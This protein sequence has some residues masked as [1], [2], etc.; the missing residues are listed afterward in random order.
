VKVVN[1][2]DARLETSTP[3]T[4]KSLVDE[5]VIGGSDPLNLL[6]YV[7][8]RLGC[9]PILWLVSQFG[10]FTVLIPELV[11]RTLDFRDSTPDVTSPCE[12]TP[13]HPEKKNS[14]RIRG[15]NPSA[16][17]PA[18]SRGKKRTSP[19]KK[20]SLRTAQSPKKKKRKKEEELV[21]DGSDEDPSEP[22]PTSEDD[23]ESESGTKDSPPPKT[24]P[25]RKQLPLPT[26]VAP[27]HN[28]RNSDLRE[29]GH[30]APEGK[31]NEEGYGGDGGKSLTQETTEKVASD[32][33]DLR[34]ISAERAA[35]KRVWVPSSQSEATEFQFS[36]TDPLDFK[37]DF[38]TEVNEHLKTMCL[39][40]CEVTL[41]DVIRKGDCGY[42]CLLLGLRELE[43]DNRLLAACQDSA[44]PLRKELAYH[45]FGDANGFKG[46]FDEGK[47]AV[48]LKN[49]TIRKFLCPCLTGDAVEIMKEYQSYRHRLETRSAGLKA[50]LELSH[51]ISSLEK[52]EMKEKPSQEQTFLKQVQSTKNLSDK[53]FGE[54]AL[55]QM[56]KEAR[57]Q[58]N[59]AEKKSPITTDT[60]VAFCHLH[61]P[62]WT[63]ESE[64][65]QEYSE[66]SMSLQLGPIL[67]ASRYKCQVVVYHLRNKALKNVYTADGRGSEFIYKGEDADSL[68]R[69]LN[70]FPVKDPHNRTVYLC[71]ADVNEEGAG[72][73][74]GH[75]TFIQRQYHEEHAH[76]YPITES[77]PPP[78][79]LVPEISEKWDESSRVL[80]YNT[81]KP[82][83]QRLSHLYARN[84]LTVI[85]TNVFDVKEREEESWHQSSILLRHES[86]Y[87]CEFSVQDYKDGLHREVEKDPSFT[88]NLFWEHLEAYKA[89]VPAKSI[90]YMKDVPLQQMAP[91]MYDDFLK[92]LT[93]KDSLPG[94]SF[95]MLKGVS[96]FLSRVCLYPWF[97][98]YR[99]VACSPPSKVPFTTRPFMGPSLYTG[100]PG[101]HT[102]LHQDGLGSVDSAHLCISGYNE[103]VI[104]RRLPEQHK[105]NAISLLFDLKEEDDTF[106]I[107]L[108][109]GEPHDN[110]VRTSPFFSFLFQLLTPDNSLL[111]KMKK[112]NRER[113]G[114]PTN[115]G[116]ERCRKKG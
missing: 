115:E 85:L 14:S 33:L 35:E 77:V 107:G 7:E 51:E 70:G 30:L 16:P 62:G 47:I 56:E 45:A 67:F 94:G 42:Y 40:Y 101:P 31:T 54:K 50:R 75:F 60:L 20:G 6:M 74:L 63:Y 73:M 34:K 21:T 38:A 83:K 37:D 86:K 90:Y 43:A 13:T 17:R 8:A 1:K 5:M 29:D 27:N 39:S 114:W 110:L 95:C 112:Q 81:S 113:P 102:H 49:E 87:F 100:P 57:E 111:P 48:L 84:D 18:S 103:V 55:Q 98:T 19:R 64:F 88:P 61:C 89:G 9:V 93:F 109:Y 32:L 52:N 36:W 92:I 91:D 76:L 58:E 2:A 26:T 46:N 68:N 22:E 116:I 71:Y 24:S 4:L 82:E 25:K 66:D 44:L 53:I 72:P 23:E 96:F 59:G 106:V 28:K 97:C 15:K 12:K 69:S 11:Q 99:N 108:M 41:R 78:P 65:H 3:I 10:R 80:K 79:E 105:R 104:L